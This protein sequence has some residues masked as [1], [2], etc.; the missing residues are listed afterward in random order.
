MIKF[1]INKEF[2]YNNPERIINAYDDIKQKILNNEMFMNCMQCKYNSKQDIY[3]MFKNIIDDYMLELIPDNIKDV[4]ELE[5]FNI[6][7]DKVYLNIWVEN[8]FNEIYN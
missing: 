4:N 8:M 1:Y 2:E 5:L 7:S 3:N 6:M